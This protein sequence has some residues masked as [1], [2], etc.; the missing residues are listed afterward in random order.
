VTQ[1]PGS[2]FVMFVG[3]GEGL[4]S[5]PV[6]AE[7]D[8]GRVGDFF[9][10]RTQDVVEEWDKITHQMMTFLEQVT[11]RIDTF[12]LE[13]VEFQLGFSAAGHLGFIATTGANASVRVTF[14]RKPPL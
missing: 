14:R 5:A 7:Q 1:E 13:E 12:D 6:G 2:Q 4:E 8:Y 10:R 9:E 11:A 3:G